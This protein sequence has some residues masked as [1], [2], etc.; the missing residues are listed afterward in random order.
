M[1]FTLTESCWPD[2]SRDTELAI[3]SKIWLCVQLVAIAAVTAALGKLSGLISIPWSFIF[4]MVL[5]IFLLGYLWFSS[6]RSS[7][8]WDCLLMRQQE[9]TEQP[10]KAERAGSIM[11]KEAISFMER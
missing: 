1:P 7:L 8:Y 9:I 2:P 6:Y 5:F 4:S 3:G 11:L 10:M